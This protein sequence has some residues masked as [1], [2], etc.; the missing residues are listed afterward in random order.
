MK[1]LQINTEKTWRGGEKQTLLTIQGLLGLD[2]QTELLCRQN[3]PLARKARKQNIIC[4]EIGTALEAMSFLTR[5]GSEY[6]I[7]HAQTAKA[8]SFAV[9]TKPFH[10]TKIVYTRRVDFVPRGFP[11]RF[12]FMHTDTVVAISKAIAQVLGDFGV[13]TDRVIPSAIDL[14]AP[15]PVPPSEIHNQILKHKQS[16][17]K[18]ILTIAAL[19]PHK[20]PH[21]MVK[22][23]SY[24][25]RIE[26]DAVFFHCGSGNL[27]SEIHALIQKQ[28]MQDYY[29]LLSFVD[30][31]EGL[32]PLADVFVMSS[33]EE[34]LGSTVLEAFRHKI[35][36]ASTDAGGLKE[37]VPGHGLISSVHDAHAL[38]ANIHTLLT[39]RNAAH[40]LTDKAFEYVCT[41]HS[42]ET[43]TASYCSLFKSMLGQ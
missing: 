14:Q 26:P 20:D 41:H 35:P 24:L 11:A 18:I 38:A 39:D 23:I 30:N 32:L 4:H 10:K 1:I 7:L 19:V 16:S 37:I 31:A 36:V 13:S 40:T 34:G 9:L 5:H 25:H 2:V 3:H 33:Q 28:E 22:A 6:D 27:E 15:S 8:Q 42:R 43:M 12:K 29:K 21:T 17:K